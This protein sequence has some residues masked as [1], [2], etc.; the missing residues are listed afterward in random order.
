M[1]CIAVRAVS[2]ITAAS[3]A[4]TSLPLHLV[5]AETPPAPPMVRGNAADIDAAGALRAFG[6]APAANAAPA[7]PPPRELTRADY[8]A[9]QTTDEPTFRKAIETITAKALS[10]GLASVDYKALVEDQWRAQGL[11]RIVDQRVDIAVAEVRDETS[12][13][14]LISSLANKDK[15][16]ALATAVAER[17]Y[18][19]EAVKAG[20]EGLATGVGRDIGKRLEVASVDASEP[21]LKCLQA[22]LG[23]RYGT[24][25]ARIVTHN[26]EGE[27]QADAGKGAAEVTS[28][29]VLRQ[30]SGG[31][32]GAAVILLRRQM[33][34]IATR[35]GQRLVGTILARLVTVVAG[36][37]GLVLIAKDIWDLRHGVLPIVASEMK[38]PA[39]KEKVREE[40]ATALSEQIRDH[41]GEISVKT[42]E[43]VIEVWH[44]F[45]RAHAMVLETAEKD[46][47]FRAYLDTLS[48]GELPRLDEVTALVLADEGPAGLQARLANGTL[49]EAVRRLPAPAMEIARST[50]SLATGFEWAAVAGD[51]IGA[52]LDHEI[53]RRAKPSELTSAS[54]TRILEV[55]DRLAIS[56]LASISR[57]A[58]D[59]LFD[60]DTAELRMLSRNMTESELE[61]LAGY[62][63]G[64][65]KAPRDRVLKALA[66]EP[67]TM[68]LIASEPLR[69]AVVTSRDQAAAVEIMLRPQGLVDPVA[70]YEDMRLAW[71]GRVQPMLIWEKHPA[72]VAAL[73]LVGLLLVLFL[74]RLLVPRRRRDAANPG[75]A[76]EHGSAGGKS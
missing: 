58:R 21:A 45:R 3:L 76:A 20:I 50:R 5:A 71:D 53:Y 46:D 61:T 57:G 27:F 31:I 67:A 22:F 11:D 16:Q 23:P 68:K 13:G 37:V 2:A 66:T 75:P 69:R 14:N 32:T 54:L 30:S 70:A 55:G 52:V 33:A 18:R 12:W 51:K 8:E 1:H 43:L 34:N 56:R 41:V 35:I 10:K 62:L 72:A 28:G 44:G 73:A 38:A 74:W 6:T 63:G 24:A 49:D 17:V 15:A 25:V 40:L 48:A 65:A 26:A 4:L 9:C 42:S 29:D 36:G 64:L 19:S 39:T 7:S 47:R 59:T 60:L